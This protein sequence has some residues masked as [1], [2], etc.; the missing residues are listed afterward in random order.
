MVAN[1]W[2]GK[3]RN[4]EVILKFVAAE[5]KGP[6]RKEMM[7]VLLDEGSTVIMVEK[8]LAE[9]NRSYRPKG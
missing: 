6:K 1:I 8:T 7:Y 5:I 4:T 2:S 9:K 3:E